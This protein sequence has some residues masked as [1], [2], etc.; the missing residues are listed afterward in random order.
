MSGRPRNPRRAAGSEAAFQDQV[1]ALAR[2]Y[3]WLHYHTHDSRR[4]APGFPDLVL[5]RAPRLIFA[6][7]KTETGRR[8]S[9]QD[10]WLDA[11]HQIA[12]ALDLQAMR[13][14]E[15][16]YAPARIEVY[17]WRPSDLQAIA[18]LL[19]GNDIDPAIGQA[20]AADRQPGV[21][22]VTPPARHRNTLTP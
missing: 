7:L 2:L 11:L 9:E 18:E 16:V 21:R 5:A 22:A 12:T 1:V 6:E 15:L 13:P 4:S 14:G 3:G 17:L 20:Y 19:A 8:T 10:R